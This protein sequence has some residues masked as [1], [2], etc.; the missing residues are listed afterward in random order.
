FTGLSDCQA[1]SVNKLDYHFNAALSAVNVA[2]VEQG[3]GQQPFSMAT[4]KTLYHNR[5]LLDRFFSILPK[6]TK[7]EKNDPRVRQLYHFGCIAA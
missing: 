3:V 4:I 5:L 1:R 7:L 2:K 6:G